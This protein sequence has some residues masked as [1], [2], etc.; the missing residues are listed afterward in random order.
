M[1]RTEPPTSSAPVDRGLVLV[2]A[3]IVALVVASVVIV[4]LATGS[5]EPQLEP[6]S[7]EAV[8]RDYLAAYEADDLETAHGFFS[9]AVRAEWDLES[10]R[11][12]ADARFEPRYGGAAR[13]VLFERAEIDGDAA[14]VSLIIEEFYGDGLSG[15]TYRSSREIRM[16]REDGG[17]RIDQPLADL[18][19]LPPTKP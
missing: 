16:V 6:G 10:Y 2:A 1:E 8:L 3:G 13:R 19:P 15:D 12:S 7:P 5:D 18:E 9:A 11:R 4:L 17:W 14:R